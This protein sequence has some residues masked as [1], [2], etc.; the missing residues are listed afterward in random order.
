MGQ[1]AKIRV[2]LN[3]ILLCSEGGFSNVPIA[4]LVQAV[5]SLRLCKL[6]SNEMAGRHTT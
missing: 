5:V 6:P 3:M 4:D 1:K 2:R